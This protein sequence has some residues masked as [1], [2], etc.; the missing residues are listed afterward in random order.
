MSENI[1]PLLKAGDM[2][3]WVRHHRTTPASSLLPTAAPGIWGVSVKA[4]GSS[5]DSE[6]QLLTSSPLAPT[7]TWSCA[8]Q[9]SIPAL[10]RHPFSAVLANVRQAWEGGL[11]IR[12]QEGLLWQIAEVTPVT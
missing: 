8:F 4:P 12:W 9:K 3:S 6:P 5:K 1:Q 11:V 7:S 10:R 2:C